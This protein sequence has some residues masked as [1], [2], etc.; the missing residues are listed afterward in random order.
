MF[1]VGDQTIL[2]HDGFSNNRACCFDSILTRVA[3]SGIKFL[4]EQVAMISFYAK[5]EKELC[6]HSALPLKTEKNHPR[7]EISAHQTTFYSANIDLLCPIA[8]EH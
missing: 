2:K 8:S 7:T 3:Q 1:A 4:N 6:T 5:I